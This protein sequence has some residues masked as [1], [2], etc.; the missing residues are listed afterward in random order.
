MSCVLRKL[1]I[2]HV[3]KVSSQNSLC[4]LHR[5]IRDDTFRLNWIFAKKRL[6]LN[7]KCHKSGKCRPWLACV[8]CTSGTSIMPSFLRTRHI[9]ETTL[10]QIKCYFDIVTYFH[11]FYLT[12]QLNCSSTTTVWQTRIKWFQWL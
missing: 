4:S 8:D 12:V 3:R 10:M 11:N 1:G 5:L 9:W 7:K 6:H 2:M